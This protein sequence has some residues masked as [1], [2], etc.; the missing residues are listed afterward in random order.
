MK[1]L[2]GIIA[3]QNEASNFGRI[4]LFGIGPFFVRLNIS[5]RTELILGASA[6]A[7]E[8]RLF[9]NGVSFYFA[10]SVLNITGYA[11]IVWP[12]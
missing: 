4:L 10:A 6:H 3:L 1:L 5:N 8:Q 11:G 9:G 2:F 7:F 12:K